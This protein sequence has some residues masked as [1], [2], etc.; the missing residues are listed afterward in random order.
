MSTTLNDSKEILEIALL[1]YLSLHNPKQYS[2][3]HY[4]RSRTELFGNE[5]KF[6]TA[7]QRRQRRSAK[8]RINY[9]TKSISTTDLIRLLKERGFTTLAGTPFE[10]LTDAEL[11][12]E[13]EKETATGKQTK[14]IEKQIEKKQSEKQAQEIVHVNHTKDRG[15]S[16]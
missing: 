1:T 10:S 11:T 2:L 9:L 12:N 6:A 15:K 14:Q 16:Y 3:N 13:A 5:S 8:N 4:A 7:A